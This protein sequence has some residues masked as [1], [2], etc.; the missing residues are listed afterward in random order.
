VS[1]LAA[2]AYIAAAASAAAILYGGLI[3]GTLEIDDTRLW[4]REVMRPICWCGEPGIVPQ[5]IE[6][7]PPV[8]RVVC[9][10]H[11]YSKLLHNDTVA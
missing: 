5:T 6:T 3:Y 9:W 7:T 4:W 2:M 10:N 8:R 11:S 1:A